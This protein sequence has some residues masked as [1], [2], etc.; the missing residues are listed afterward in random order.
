MSDKKKILFVDDEAKVLRGIRRML[1]FKSEEWD[2]T[3]AGNGPEALSALQEKSYD[4]IVTDIRMPGMDGATLLNNV[5]RLHPQMARIALSGQTSQETIFK[6]IGPTH[7]FLS[8]PC[9]AEILETT[10]TRICSLQSLLKNDKILGLISELESLPSLST[11]YTELM[12]QLHSDNASV[13]AVGEIVSRDVGMT[14]KILQLVN[15]AFFGIKQRIANIP[16]AVTLLGLDT[17]KALV[18]SVKIFSQF[19]PLKLENFSP[20]SLWDH[21]ST[22]GKWSQLIAKMENADQ[23][24]VDYATLAGTLHDV[25][26]L[27]FATKIPQQYQES[28]SL[29]ANENI[30]MYAAEREVIG[31]THAEVGAYLL[32]LWGF[33]TSI[34][35]ALAFH[36]KPAEIATKEF[37]ALTAVHAANVLANESCIADNNH[38]TSVPIDMEYLSNLG[39]SERYTMW[40][41]YCREHTQ[42]G[43]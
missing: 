14:A 32:G 20:S 31:T 23:I 24:T 43:C 8:K 4:V 28:L 6:A 41:E 37:T 25:G 1:S 27:I 18:L 15:S 36:H 12:E 29:M 35:E 10:I 5:K 3:F 30:P 2:T 39:L 38:Q 26:K 21:S 34:V 7:Q 22:V 19:T 33:S 17:I 40:Q 16:R 13:E 9:D 11:L 42:V